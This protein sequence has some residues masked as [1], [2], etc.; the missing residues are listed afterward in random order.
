MRLCG[1][2]VVTYSAVLA[3][4]GVAYAQ[5]EAPLTVSFVRSAPGN[6][7]DADVAA[8]FA[9]LASR[10]QPSRT[11]AVELGHYGHNTNCTL[12][13]NRTIASIN[14]GKFIKC[15]NELPGEFIALFS[16]V[17]HGEA[18]PYY[19]VAF[20][21]NATSPISGIR[22][23]DIDRLILG[24]EASISGYV[25]PL[26]RLYR[27][28][29]ISIPNVAA[30]ERELGWKVV[31]VNTSAE[32]VRELRRSN[33]AIGS[34]GLAS[35]TVPDGMKAIL[36]HGL[37]PQDVLFISSDLA[38]D[39]AIIATWFDSVMAD[40]AKSRLLREYTSS[41]SGLRRLNPEMQRAYASLGAMIADVDNALAV[42]SQR[43]D[44]TP[45]VT[46][47]YVQWALIVLGAI[48][49]CS[50]IVLFSHRGEEGSNT[51]KILGQEFTL[52]GSSLVIVVL[53]V[54]VI[55][56]AVKAL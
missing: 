54:V 20:L 8:L 33:S 1:L 32:I 21:T 18:S 37:Y 48:F 14:P 5:S 24:P 19:S 41:I 4:A 27:D 52:A 31:H 7:S 43:D 3:H 22:S 25:A 45:S 39:T 2:L 56:V 55:L 46:I 53:G 26:Y 16:V 17:K 23:E 47:D 15:S 30:V 6:A 34:V 12:L 44:V 50:G 36:R 28:K 51:I 10:I 42:R 40:P 49:T 38:A 35:D 11:S 29:H 9:E 13:A